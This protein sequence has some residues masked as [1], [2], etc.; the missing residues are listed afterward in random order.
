LSP[1]PGDK[2]PRIWLTLGGNYNA[3][4]R[5]GEEP[6]SPVNAPMFPNGLTSPTQLQKSPQDGFDWEGGLSYRSSNSDWS[7]KA[8][9]RYG[10]SS[11]NKSVHESLA[12]VTKTALV[13]FG[14]I[15]V[16]CTALASGQPDP[17]CSVAAYERFIDSKDV[18]SEEH[19]ILD[20]SLGKDVGIGTFGAGESTIS[21]GIRVAQFASKSDLTL[22][23]DAV[24]HFVP[25]TTQKYHIV[26]EFDSR[27]NRSFHG[28]GPELSWD[29]SHLILG[30][31]D[32]GQVSLD[33][34]LN[35]GILFGRQSV[36]LNHTTSECFHTN[37]FNGPLNPCQ[38][39][40]SHSYPVSRSRTVTV[41]NLGGYVGASMRYH[42]AKI[43]LGYRADTFFNAMD[44]GQE[45]HKAYNRGFYG[46]YLN[47]SLGLG[48]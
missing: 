27:D 44:G 32:D 29:A 35:V 28:I 30:N 47:V 18:S 1:D 48:G 17:R 16:P 8:G 24:N 38:S 37:N 26:D 20:F 3:T 45:T 5:A 11:R 19:M 14:A 6:W 39:T 12:P 40:A 34:G 42:N 22:G 9:V 25:T 33:W 46:P 2:A 36:K 13:E 31:A 4:I 41:P 23:A 7:L 43:S 15:H 21:S 10:R